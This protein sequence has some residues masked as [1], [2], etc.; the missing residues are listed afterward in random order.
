MEDAKKDVM[1]GSK[2]PSME[3]MRRGA[4]SLAILGSYLQSS[5]PQHQSTTSLPPKDMDKD[6]ETVK[7]AIDS[8]FT[9]ND[10]SR[11]KDASR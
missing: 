1:F 2:Q 7:N 3:Q 11:F 6:Q 4:S 10:A 9:R 8:K 5:D